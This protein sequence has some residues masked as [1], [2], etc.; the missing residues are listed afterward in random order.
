M[1]AGA[2]RQEDKYRVCQEEKARLWEVLSFW[3]MCKNVSVSVS[4]CVSE[5]I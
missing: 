4:V 1:C 5:C 3:H 2:S